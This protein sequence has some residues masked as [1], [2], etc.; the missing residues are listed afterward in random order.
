MSVQLKS[1]D[2]N[3]ITINLKYAL[4]SDF[5][6]AYLE[7][8]DFF[9]AEDRGEPID[10]T[11]NSTEIE[12]FVKFFIQ[13]IEHKK[14]NE[15]SKF[16]PSHE[17]SLSYFNGLSDET[18]LTY[19]KIAEYFQAPLLMDSIN[20]YIGQLFKMPKNELDM[21]YGGDDELYEEARNEAFEIF[22]DVILEKL[23]Q[24][25]PN[26]KNEEIN[27]KDKYLLF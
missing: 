11:L 22:G 7:E 27:L 15:C 13:A 10:V 3:T 19:Q 5:I 23:Y 18:I 20:L 6:T 24:I 16:I 8:N 4:F 26:F 9:E 21:L 12:M 1:I 25:D 2:Q 17:F 14:M